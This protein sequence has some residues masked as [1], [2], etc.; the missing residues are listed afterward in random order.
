M[1]ITIPTDTDILSALPELQ[2]LSLLDTGGFKAVYKATINGRTEALKLI[3]ISDS[4]GSQNAE[5][6]KSENIGRVRREVEALGRCNGPEIVKLGALALRRYSAV[7]AR[8]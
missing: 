6:F 2:N 8:R 7:E 1:P 3:Q 4:D 5:A